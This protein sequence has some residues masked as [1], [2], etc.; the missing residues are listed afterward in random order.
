RLVEVEL[1]EVRAGTEDAV[2]RTLERCRAGVSR[3]EVRVEAAGSDARV[4]RDPLRV[5]RRAAVDQELIGAVQRQLAREGDRRAV[6]AEHL[7]RLQLA[8]RRQI[9]RIVRY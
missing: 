3:R 4:D 2:L 9:R 6:G 1:A 7:Q 8:A 5:E